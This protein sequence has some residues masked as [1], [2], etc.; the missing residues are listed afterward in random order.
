M[1][2]ADDHGKVCPPHCNASSKQ[3][4]DPMKRMVPSVSM[5]WILVFNGRAL[6]AVSALFIFKKSDKTTNTTNPMGTFLKVA[7]GSAPIP[8]F[9]RVLTSRSTIS[10]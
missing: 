5:R 9:D 3:Q 6:L 2:V 7:Q 4:M 8:R 10:N 1:T